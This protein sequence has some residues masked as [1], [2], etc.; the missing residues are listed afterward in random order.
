MEEVPAW[1]LVE[2]LSEAVVLCHRE[3]MLEE[4]AE[5]CLRGKVVSYQV[6]WEAGPVELVRALAPLAPAT[7]GTRAKLQVLAEA[8]ADNFIMGLLALA[9]A[10]G[11]V[12][13]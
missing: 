4:L 5:T 1:V 11:Q 13:T 6:V 12:L 7:K 2:A 8:S 9:L 10:M 3:I